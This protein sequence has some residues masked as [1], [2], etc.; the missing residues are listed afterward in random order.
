[1]QDHPVEFDAEAVARAWNRAADAYAQGQAAGRDYYRYEFLGPAGEEEGP[2]IHADNTD[3][4]R[5]LQKKAR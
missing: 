4:S 3:Q 2:Q 1:L 5:N